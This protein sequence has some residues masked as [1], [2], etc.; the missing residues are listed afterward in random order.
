MISAARATR[1]SII[2]LWADAQ[3]LDAATISVIFGLSAAVD[4]L[5]FYPGGAI[6]DRY[7]RVFVA[8]PAMIVLGA[9]LCPAAAGAA[10]SWASRPSPA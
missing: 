2:P 6:M 9:G 10:M 1:Q 5:L 8:V 7:G 4:M 3:G